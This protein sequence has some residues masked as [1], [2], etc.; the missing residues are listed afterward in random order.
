VQQIQ[1][2][3]NVDALL[4]MTGDYIAACE[5][6]LREGEASLDQTCGSPANDAGGAPPES[7]GSEA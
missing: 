3:K 4:H 5:D 6:E 7:K 2:A 1:L